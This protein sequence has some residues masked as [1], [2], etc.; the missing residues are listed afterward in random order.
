MKRA[1]LLGDSIRM[2]YDS[3]VKNFYIMM[4]LARDNANQLSSY[5]LWQMNQCFKNEG[6]F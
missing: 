3:M 1:I 2:G 5:T 4:N 6:S